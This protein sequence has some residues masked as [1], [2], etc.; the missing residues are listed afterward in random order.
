M[1][2]RVYRAAMTS[3]D[4][5]LTPAQART[6][7]AILEAAGTVLAAERTAPLSAVADAAGVGR[8]TLHRYFPERRDLVRGLAEHVFAETDRRVAEARVDVGDPVAALRRILDLLLD[9]GP[10]IAFVYQEAMITGEEDHLPTADDDT[11]PLDTVLDRLGE[12]LRPDVPRV[13]AHRAFWALMYAGWES[14]AEEPGTPRHEAIDA[15]MAI[16][17]GGVLRDR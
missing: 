4:A 2:T 9:L 15:I 8:T 7:R 5:R 12:R 11:H 3:P 6:R 1:R 17:T 10:Q 14:V 13:W 16:Y